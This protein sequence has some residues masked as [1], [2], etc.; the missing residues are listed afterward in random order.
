MPKD[1]SPS[2]NLLLGLLAPDD[3]TLLAPDLEWVDLPL[4]YRLASEGALI[5][6]VYFPEEGIASVTTHIEHDVSVEIGI[7]GREGV[8]NVSV[9]VGNQRSVNNACMQVEGS[10]LRIAAGKL[11]AAAQQSST[12]QA[13]MLRYV[14]VFMVQAT[15]TA[16][17]NARATI[18]ERLS[19]WLLMAHDRV[20]APRAW[21]P[22]THASA[23]SGPCRPGREPSAA[24]ALGAR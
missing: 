13:I 12:L 18:T 11:I 16:L 7:I 14:H 20:G 19:R 6:W 23:L 24:T 15:A 8:A 17:A 9:L 22:G 10:G 2:K 21:W 1:L 5:E 4:R 3:L